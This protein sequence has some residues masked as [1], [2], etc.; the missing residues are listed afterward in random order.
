MY[1]FSNPDPRHCYFI[2]GLDTPAIS[3]STVLILARDREIAVP[4]GY[5]LDISHLF[6]AWFVWGFWGTIYQIVIFAVFLPLACTCTS[7][8]HILYISGAI[9]ETIS[10]CNTIA[11]L[12]L[13]F[14]WR[15][16]SGGSTCSGDKLEKLAGVS[17]E[18]WTAAL[19]A[20]RDTDG[21]QLQ[22]GKFMHVF[23]IISFVLVVLTIL[24]G[25][26]IAI[27]RSCNTSD[28]DKLPNGDSK[29]PSNNKE[30]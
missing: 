7:N 30:S 4:D 15:Y 14:F 3:K 18:D 22:S 11:W 23:I 28:Q 29:N 1:T 19:T 17:N 5:P 8:V 20:A 16:S 24:C 13:G 9:A 10:C 21:Y 2:K 6:R 26:C 25:S 12:I 27:A